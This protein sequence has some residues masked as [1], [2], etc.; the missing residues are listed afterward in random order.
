MLLAGFARCCPSV[1]R[2]ESMQTKSVLA[3]SRFLECATSFSYHP[4]QQNSSTVELVDH[5]HDL[6]RRRNWTSTLFTTRRSSVMLFSITPNCCRFL[7]QL[8]PALVAQ[9]LARFW[10]TLRVARSVCANRACQVLGHVSEQT[11]RKTD[12]QTDRLPYD[13]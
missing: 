7:V 9:Q 12:R 5:T 11:Y 3:S 13:A 2:F 1:S 6:T 4:C 10:T 8:V